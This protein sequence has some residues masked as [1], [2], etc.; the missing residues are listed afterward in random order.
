M[1]V[2]PPIRDFESDEFQQLVLN[3]RDADSP[4]QQEDS[5]DKLRD[6]INARL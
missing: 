5:R 6:Y 2:K 1:R 4:K 3:V